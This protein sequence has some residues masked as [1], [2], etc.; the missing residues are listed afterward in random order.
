MLKSMLNIVSK[1]CEILLITAALICLAGSAYLN[2]RMTIIESYTDPALL[3]PLKLFWA[4]VNCGM[5]AFT[6][7]RIRF[8]YS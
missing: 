4:G 2:Y 8:Y 1:S 3:M 7:N 5:I 6:L